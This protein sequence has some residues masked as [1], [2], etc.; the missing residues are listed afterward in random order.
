MG[1]AIAMG[2]NHALSVITGIMALQSRPIGVFATSQASR[3]R[4]FEAD[5]V[6]TIMIRY[7]NG[8]TAVCC[9]NIDNGCGYD[10]YHN[11]HGTAGGFVFDAQ[12]ERPQKVRYWSEQTKGRWAFPLD[13]ARCD[14]DGLSELAWPAEM[15]TPDSGNV[16]GNVIEHQLGECLVHFIN[17]VQ[18]RTQSPLSFGSSSLIA[19]IGWAARMSAVQK[20]EIALPLD[21]GEAELFFR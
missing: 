8:A 12:Q 18:A 21:L 11:L 3:V 14:R 7:E 4:G 20:R 6:W 5:P 10:A 2:I 15:L 16:I 19:E 13:P 9:G 1:D 17:C